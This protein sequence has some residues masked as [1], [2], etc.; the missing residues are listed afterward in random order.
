MA[1][2]P[3]VTRLPRGRLLTAGS[4]VAAVGVAGLVRTW[5]LRWGADKTEIGMS[6]LGDDLL[7]A[8]DL[9]ATRAIT[10]DAD[11]AAV[12]PWLAQLGQGR[13]GFY[14]YDRL[15][16]L[17]GCDIHSAD[18]VIAEFQQI[19]VGDEVSL[20]PQI[21][22]TVAHAQSMRGLVLRGAVPLAGS[23]APY[24]FTWAFVLFGGPG[25]PTRLV[26]RE[27]YAYLRPWAALLVEPVEMIS[28]I[29]S[30]RMLRGIAERAAELQVTR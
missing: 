11:L 4:L 8:A 30:R 22:L 5:S 16:N 19:Q 14:S 12:W 26:V 9:I 20:H 1:P 28:F 21:A 27:R 24:D 2:E 10:I 17:L 6:L 7:P 29:M 13:G 23:P 3:R 15:E 18:R 25:E